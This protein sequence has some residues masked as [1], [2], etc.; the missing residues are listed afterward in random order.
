MEKVRNLS[1]PPVIAAHQ[2]PDPHNIH[3]AIAEGKELAPGEHLSEEIGLARTEARTETIGLDG[4]CG[5]PESTPSRTSHAAQKPNNG[6]PW[7]RSTLV[8]VEMAEIVL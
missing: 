6:L 5:C 3:D 8:N 7:P 4:A 2:A 1:H